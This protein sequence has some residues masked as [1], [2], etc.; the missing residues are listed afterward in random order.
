MNKQSKYEGMTLV[1]VTATVAIIALMVAITIPAVNGFLRSF[2][3]ENTVR[4]MVNAALSSARSMAL[5]EQRDV[6]VRF[7]EDLDGNQYMIFI[8]HDYQATGLRPG[9]RAVHGLKPIKLPDTIRVMDGLV[10]IN[11]ADTDSGAEDENSEPIRWEHFDDTDLANTRDYGE[12]TSRHIERN[13][14]LMDTSTFSVVFSSRG[15][16][17]MREVRVRST[18]EYQPISLDESDDDV[19]NSPV[20]IIDHETGMF[21]QDDYAHLGL[22]A[23]ISRNNLVIYDRKRFQDMEFSSERYNY[24][25]NLIPLFV[26]PYTGTLI[27]P[28]G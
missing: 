16:L 18:D 7:Q 25:N 14:Y 23:E 20:N 28:Q 24:I 27:V 15:H 6:G 11:H 8:V 3:S 13:I 4:M 17:I 9:F 19:F 5:S 21:I 22:G 26:S 10:R 1:E 12:G 2:E